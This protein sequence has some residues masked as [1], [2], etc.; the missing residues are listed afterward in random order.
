MKAPIA[1][2]PKATDR[3]NG[4]DR[5]PDAASGND[6]PSTLGALPRR[7]ARDTAAPPLRVTDGHIIARGPAPG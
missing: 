6:S 4:Q 5:R 2:A 7:P 3:V 1:L